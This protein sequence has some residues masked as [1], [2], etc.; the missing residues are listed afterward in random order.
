[1]LI[2]VNLIEKKKNI[3]FQQEIILYVVIDHDIV[4][5]YLY[6]FQDENV[7]RDVNQLMMIADFDFDD[8]H[9]QTIH[10]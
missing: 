8:Q 5:M 4:Q 9:V 6:L 10:T 3:Q 1:M 7:Y 2:V